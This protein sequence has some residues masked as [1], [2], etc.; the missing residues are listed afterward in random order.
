MCGATAF[1]AAKALVRLSSS[2]RRQVAASVS[3]SDPPAKPPTAPTRTSTRPRA[4]MVRSTNTVI[5]ARSV[6]STGSVT[7]RSRWA[8][9]TRER[10]SARSVSTAYGTATI[11]PS[12]R[13][14]SV[15]AWPS[16]P[17][18]PVTIATRFCSGLREAGATGGWPEVRGDAASSGMS[19]FTLPGAAGPARSVGGLRQVRP[20]VVRHV[21]IHFTGGRGAGAFGGWPETRGAPASSGMSRF[22][23]TCSLARGD[24]H[25][26]RALDLVV[27]D[28]GDVE[29]L[30]VRAE[31]LEGLL[32]GRQRFARPG[33]RR[34][35]GQ[36]VVLHVGVVDA[37]LLDLRDALP[38][39]RVRLADERGALPALLEALRQGELQ[40]LVPPPQDRRE[41]PARESLVLFV[42]EAE[43]DEVGGLELR[44]PALLGARGLVLRERP[45]H[46]DDLE[47]FLLQ[48]VRLLDVEGEDLED[49]L[50]LDDE[51]RGHPLDPELVE[52]R[53]TVVPVG[54]PVHARLGRDHD[55]R[56]HEAIE[57]LDGL[58]QALDVGRREVALVGARLHA[59]ARQQAEDL[60]VVPERLLVERER[61][62]AV[63]LDLRRKRLGLGGRFPAHLSQATRESSRS[64]EPRYN[65]PQRAVDARG[66][67][68]DEQDQEQPVD[69]LGHA[70]QPEPE[71]HAEVLAERD[72]ERRPHGGTE[73]RVHPAEDDGE[74][75]AERDTDAGEGVRVHIRD[76]LGVRHATDRR[77]ARREHRDPHL[78]PGHVDAD[79]RRGGFVLT[80]RL[81]RRP[82]HRP[83]HTVPDP[84]PGEPED[85]GGVVED[86]LVGELHGEDAIVWR[87]PEGEAEGAARPV[88]LGDDQQAHA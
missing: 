22:V 82:R 37:P 86:A 40:E 84:E 74:H 70:D 15:T 34:G 80:D 67:E 73:E 57:P 56:V 17:V 75:D 47:R 41:R 19:R 9:A 14:R 87:G 33:E 16:A 8:G 28:P 61:R 68:D 52:H 62:A 31:L 45:V 11:A 76:V 25:D 21:A 43:R 54:R 71:D 81:H 78:E 77:E 24:R 55:D 64:R 46:P 60:P 58:G 49:H 10:S 48:V 20:G 44:L 2:I 36:H 4:T 85:Q 38:R 6:T 79:G 5:A 83:V 39:G 1:V 88:P 23:P 51:D 30:E 35:A 13:N 3:R 32:E 7:R 59:L 66:E 72:R 27:T 65:I 42:E 26:R 12:A 29:R 50:G 18:P 63:A 53:A 69:R